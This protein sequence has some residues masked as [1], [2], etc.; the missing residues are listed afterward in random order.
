VSVLSLSGEPCLPFSGLDVAWDRDLDGPGGRRRQ[1]QPPRAPHGSTRRGS[2]NRPAAGGDD[3]KKKCLHRG[4]AIG[5]TRAWPE[6]VAKSSARA[7]YCV[8]GAEVSAGR[9][10]GAAHPTNCHEMLTTRTTAVRM[11][12][13][14]TALYWRLSGAITV[15]C[16]M[17]AM[18]IAYGVSIWNRITWTLQDSGS[19]WIGVSTRARCCV[20]TWARDSNGNSIAGLPLTFRAMTS[21]SLP[22]ILRL[23]PDSQL[24]IVIPQR[25]VLG[26]YGQF[27]V[28]SIALPTLVPL[29]VATIACGHLIWRVFNQARRS[30]LCRMNNC[31]S[32]GYSRVGAV[33][34]RCPECGDLW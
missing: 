33:S 25:V 5:D 21:K 29:L 8:R 11:K 1:C 18:A 16:C 14:M 23:I 15:S 3:R 2:Q 17:L 32:C 4:R 30:R 6:T 26:P 31:I 28:T 9:M 22:T 20:V 27:S 7:R 13:R 10:V 19:S 12:R 34:A 24:P